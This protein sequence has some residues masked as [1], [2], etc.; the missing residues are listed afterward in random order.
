[1][2]ERII[3]EPKVCP[4]CGSPIVRLLDDGANIYCS[5]PKCPE[6]QL[7]KLN[8]FV[9]KECMNIDG[10]S[11]KTLRKLIDALD[12]HTWDD[13]YR[14]KY[15][16]ICGIPGIGSKTALKI[17]DELWNSRT[18]V[19]P[20]NVLMALGIPMV[21]KVTASLLISHFKSIKNLES[22][23]LSEIASIDGV[24]EVA[25][26]YIYDYM[27]TAHEELENVYKY[28]QYEVDENKAQG[29]ISDKLAG[30]ILM[31]TGTLQ[32]F[33]RDG[34]RA[35]VIENGGTYASGISGKL[36][37][38]IVGDKAGDSKLEKAKKLGIKMISE[39]EYIEMISD[40]YS[41]F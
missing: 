9:T 29:A 30:L 23:E 8:Y 16:D 17:I 41:L 31:A 20:E 37:Y 3:E 33:S 24:G 25:A 27:S 1:M 10:L 39:E 13:L 40:S 26:K 32:G 7:A 12:I 4:F 15:D 21:G 19:D 36:D 14:L 22:A 5:N 11:A 2:Q 18:A 35:S 34:I 6:R 28:L 38:L